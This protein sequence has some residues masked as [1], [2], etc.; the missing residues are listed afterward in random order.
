MG[1]LQLPVPQFPFHLHCPCCLEHWPY[2]WL[3]CHQPFLSQA[4]TSLCPCLFFPPLLLHPSIHPPIHPSIHPSIHLS[5]HPPSVHLPTHSLIHLFI[6][7]SIS[8]PNLASRTKAWASVPEGSP[9][10]SSISSSPQSHVC[11]CSDL[12]CNTPSAICFKEGEGSQKTTSKT[13]PGFLVPSELC[14][15]SQE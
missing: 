3:C 12:Q 13:K 1:L 5:I 10:A 7:G 11:K 6:H 4:A 2:S 15:K 9:N 14:E 8:P